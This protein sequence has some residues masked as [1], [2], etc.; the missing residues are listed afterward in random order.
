MAIWCTL[1]YSVLVSPV[2]I[3]AG[4]ILLALGQSPE[5]A[6]LGPVG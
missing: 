3:F 5:V 2:F 4:P 6:R 1:A